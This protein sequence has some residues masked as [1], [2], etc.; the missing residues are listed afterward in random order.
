MNPHIVVEHNVKEES[1]NVP[2][3]LV[4]KKGKIFL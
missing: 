4:L 3:Y 1:D 2:I